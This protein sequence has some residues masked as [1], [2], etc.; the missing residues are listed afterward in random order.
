MLWTVFLVFILYQIIKSCFSRRGR[1]ATPSRPASRPSGGSW[2]PGHHS[3]NTEPPPP[4]YSRH[5][6]PFPSESVGWTPG[7]WTG[8]TLG[9]L[10]A[11]MW[12]RRRDPVPPVAPRRSFW[13]W[14]RPYDWGRWSTARQAASPATPSGGWFRGA[15]SGS[16][17]TWSNDNRGEGTSSMGAMRSSTG[18]GGSSVR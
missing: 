6:K 7:F 1:N 8:L 12:G 9:G 4:P 16:Q 13:D 15:G 17:R 11:S 18:W 3:D 5:R 10:G 14:E 2:F